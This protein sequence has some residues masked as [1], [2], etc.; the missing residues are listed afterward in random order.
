MENRTNSS[1]LIFSRQKSSRL[2]YVLDVLFN[3]VL[4]VTYL[5]TTDPIFFQKWKGPRINYS[6]KSISEKE[7]WIQASAFLFSQSTEK[8]YVEV[9]RHK[10]LA[11]GF[12]PIRKTRAEIPFDL[13]AFCFHLLSRYEEY[14]ASEIDFDT[15]GRFMATSSLAYQYKFLDQPVINQ[16]A[17]F[18][19]NRILEDWPETGFPP[20]S[21]K[22]IPT[23]DIDLA[24]AYRERPLWRM[25][26]GGLRDVTTGSVQKIIKRWMVLRRREADPFDTFDYIQSIHAS[27]GFDPM[28]FFLLA[29]P[30]RYD[31]NI[32]PKNPRLQQLV[33]TISETYTVGIHPSYSSHTKGG[34]LKTEISRL[35]SISRKPVIN[36][37]F[38]FLKFRLPQSFRRLIQEEILNDYSMGYPSQ[39]GF[40]AGIAT[41]FPWYDLKTETSTALIIHPFAVMDA[42]LKNYLGQSPDES[43]ELVKKLIDHTASVKGTFVTLWHNS[44]FSYI[45]GWENWGEM[46]EEILKYCYKYT[47]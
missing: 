17:L 6:H 43:L 21:F 44:S 37:R 3:H 31:R 2:S 20:L 12:F 38:H 36:S 22:F 4:Q 32:S 35:T 45:E 23:F 7:I 26:A 1:L 30:G 10:E 33:K 42:T 9:R 24:W 34:L 5:E 40:R 18:L 25:L 13:F 46:Y 47:K 29:N 28:F 15:H 14:T 11:A 41:P 8:I 16:W 19:K 39:A 27:Y